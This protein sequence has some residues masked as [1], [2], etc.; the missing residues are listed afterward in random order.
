MVQATN[1]TDDQIEQLTRMLADKGKLVAVGWLSL[2]AKVIDRSTP[3]RTAQKLHDAYFAGAQHVFASMMMMLEAGE[4]AT[5]K[6]LD[7]MAALNK[8]LQDWADDY[9]KRTT[10]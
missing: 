10:N 3:T 4:E 6:D 1:L 7:R 9:K 2:S 5:E 8:E